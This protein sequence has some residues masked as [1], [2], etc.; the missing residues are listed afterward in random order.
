V[1]KAIARHSSA[2]V[3][4]AAALLLVVGAAVIMERLGLSMSLGAFLSGLL[5]ADSE[6]GT[7]WKPTSSPSKAFCWDCSS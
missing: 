7:S 2:E 3:F 6:F 1:L 5:L 4:T